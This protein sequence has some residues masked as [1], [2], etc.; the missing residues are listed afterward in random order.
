MLAATA[1]LAAL[2]ALIAKNSLGAVRFLV[3]MIALS[4]GVEAIFRKAS[5]RPIHA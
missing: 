1:C 4:F 3:A 2:A 5:G